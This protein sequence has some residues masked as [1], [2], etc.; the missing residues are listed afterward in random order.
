MGAMDRV[1]AAVNAVVKFALSPLSPVDNRG[2]W[3]PWIR[4]PFSGAWQQGVEWTTD[5]VLAH[6]AVYTCV[7]LIA[8]DI[9]KLRP[10]LVQ[11]DADGIWTEVQS[12]AFSPVLRRPNR[13]QNHIQFK[14]WWI[15]SKLVRGN[16]YALKERD[17]RGVVKALY[18]L[19]PSRVKV[20]VAP[21]GDVF[22]QLNADNMS[23]LEEA[24]TVPSSEII[25]DRMNCL[26]HPLV[27]ISPIYAS[28][29]AATIG[30]RIEKN[31][32]HF[33]GSGS[34]PS[35]TLSAPDTIPTEVAKRL[36]ET[37][38][39]EFSG[40]NSG[41]V[42]VLGNNLKFEPL[43]MTAVDSQMIEHL[44]WTAETVASTFHVPKFKIGVG[45][46]PTYQNGEILNLTY[47]T[48][49]LQ[50]H[51]EQF[52]ACL[53]EGLG[54]ETK[55]EGRQL[56]VELDLDGLLRMDT[57]TQ[58]KTLTDG[59]KGALFT[60]DEARGKI[61]LRPIPGGHTVYMQQQNYSLAALDARDRENPAPGTTTGHVAP[62][63]PPA[64]EPDV[65]EDEARAFFERRL[66]RWRTAA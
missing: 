24:I 20:L 30:L 59:I 61:D 57:A 12:P 52:E 40:E 19:D 1:R 62:E 25:H 5:T 14:E 41:K 65:T 31:S 51:I 32:A 54:L 34:N 48:D 44:G 9:G 37:W 53:D 27:G 38:N 63:P 3:S 2:G 17:N 42:A 11:Q 21:T 50:S 35:G 47:Y 45:Q 56:G 58:I 60:P 55:T 13:Y 26:F 8:S 39:R 29:M 22:Y 18:I 43:R 23:G 28:G 10:K 4:E 16:T 33:F 15:T 64:E 46:M 6:H 66:D 36:S 7:T 49:C